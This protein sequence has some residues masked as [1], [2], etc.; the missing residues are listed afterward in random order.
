MQ[1][2]YDNDP[3]YRIIQHLDLPNDATRYIMTFLG[4]SGILKYTIEQKNYKTFHSMCID[5]KYIYVTSSSMNISVYDLKTGAHVRTM[6]LEVTRLN[7]NMHSNIQVYKNSIYHITLCENSIFV[8]NNTSGIYQQCM[9]PGQSTNL[10]GLYIYNNVMYAT[11]CRRHCIIR[12]DL[13]S[14]EY[15]TTVYHTEL[16]EPH[17]IFIY[18]NKIAVSCYREGDVLIFDIND[19]QD[20]K[21]TY[22]Y[23]LK[24]ILPAF[25][26]CSVTIDAERLY[27]I[28]NDQHAIHIFNLVSGKYL[29]EI[30]SWHQQYRYNS[31]IKR[32]QIAMS[33]DGNYLV[34]CGTSDIN[35][36]E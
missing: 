22:L 25:R 3:T 18:N 24:K 12:Y 21:I 13:L 6:K 23:K 2:N 16:D 26:S 7:I 36:F 17:G 8:N 30:R 35:V 5:D 19:K 4:V 20:S 31:F 29:R 32:R 27:I 28:Y 14:N 9:M 33:P 11:D 10:S 34:A 1:A 15:L